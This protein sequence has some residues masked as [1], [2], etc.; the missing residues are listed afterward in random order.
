MNRTFY[1]QIFSFS[2]FILFFFISLFVFS[3][4]TVK[5]VADYD[6]SI[7]EE[8]LQIAK[9]VDLFWGTLIDTEKG[10][11]EYSHFKNEYNE[12]ESDIRI[13]KL[14]NNIR[15]FNHISTRQVSVALDLWI[16]DKKSHKKKNSFSNFLAKRHRQQF[17]RLFTAIAKGEEEKN[18]TAIS[19]K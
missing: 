6:A 8:T 1:M 3:G 4:C 19:A 7:K 16:E 5:Y 2:K 9:K 11:R 12:I 10:Q 17:I 15:A 14:K 18:F 13:L